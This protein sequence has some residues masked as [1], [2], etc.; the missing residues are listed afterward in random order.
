MFSKKFFSIPVIL[1]LFLFSACDNFLSGS[2]VKEELEKT[3]SYEL[4]T[5][6][7]V[8]IYA[9]KETGSI[10]PNN[11][12]KKC[13][14][15]DKIDLEF[16]ESKN[17]KFSRWI[18]ENKDTGELLTDSVR[19]YN[20]TSTICTAEILKEANIL[21]KPL[22]YERPF[23]SDFSPVYDNTGVPKNSTIHLLFNH[24]LSS[25][26]D[27]SRITISINGEK[28]IRHFYQPVMT[29]KEITIIADNE[30][31]IQTDNNLKEISVRIPYDF[32]YT[33]ESGE[34][35]T[36]GSS[37]NDD[38]VKT[39]L[40]NNTTTEK[41][42]IT[43]VENKEYGE[44]IY[45]GNSVLNYGDKLSAQFIPK[46]GYKF[47]NW[48][49]IGS[50]NSLSFENTDS[51]VLDF[52]STGN[53][54]VIL[55]PIVVSKPYVLEYSPKNIRSGVN[56]D[57]LIEI[58][59]NTA[60]DISEFRFTQ[61]ELDSISDRIPSLDC[62][63][64]YGVYAYYTNS[65][66]KFFKNL[67]IENDFQ[68]NISVNFNKPLLS[69]D[70]KI[71]TIEADYDNLIN[72][73][74]EAYSTITV[75]LS[76][77]VKNELSSLGEDFTWE[78]KINSSHDT[79]APSVTN[80]WIAKTQAD[81]QNGV[82]L[83][84][85]YSSIKPKF[86]EKNVVNN[87]LWV[88]IDAIDYGSGVSGV[89][90]IAKRIEDVKG[91]PVNEDVKT[92]QTEFAP[93][94]NENIKMAVN[95]PLPDF[96][97]GLIETDFYVKDYL[98]N[99]VKCG[100]YV[101]VKDTKLD[102]SSVRLFNRSP[103]QT[104]LFSPEAL[105]ES[106][107][108]IYIAGAE[109]IFYKDYKSDYDELTYKAYWGPDKNNPEYT[110]TDFSFK[111]D[112]K[113]EEKEAYFTI[114]TIDKTKHNYLK[115]E[116]T[117]KAGNIGVV[118]WVIPGAMN[119]PVARQKMD[120]S[121]VDIRAT[122]DESF[123]LDGVVYY[124][125]YFLHYYIDGEHFAEE[126][127]SPYGENDFQK[128]YRIS[129]WNGTTSV[130]IRPEYYEKEYEIYIQPYLRTA[131]VDSAKLYAFV[132]KYYQKDDGE[133]SYGDDKW[134]SEY[135]SSPLHFKYMDYGLQNSVLGGVI[136]PFKVKVSENN[137]NKT[138]L[139]SVD[140]GLVVSEVNRN[141]TR[142]LITYSLKDSSKLNSTYICNVTRDSS[143]N[144]I[145]SNTGTFDWPITE[146]TVYYNLSSVI[147]G[148]IVWTDTI[149]Q[150]LNI[151]GDVTPPEIE[152]KEDYSYHILFADNNCY[153]ARATDNV[154]LKKNE[155]D[156]VEYTY[157]WVPES[158]YRKYL[159]YGNYTDYEELQILLQ[160]DLKA[161]TLS[162][163]PSTDTSDYPI[164]IYKN[165]ISYDPNEEYYDLY[166]FVS[167][168]S[169]NYAKRVFNIYPSKD[170]KLSIQKNAAGNKLYMLSETKS[171][172]SINLYYLK[173]SN[174]QKYKNSI[175]SWNSDGINGYSS[176]IYAGEID[177]SG[178]NNASQPA[179][180]NRF[181]R[182]I[183][184]KD[185]SSMYFKPIYYYIG[186]E[187]CTVKQAVESI[188]PG[189]HQIAV[190][191]DAPW[192][193][194]ILYSIDNFEDEDLWVANA[195]YTDI[196]TFTSS[197]TY[198]FSTTYNAVYKKL[199]P[200]NV[201]VGYYYRAMIIFADGT[202]ELGPVHKAE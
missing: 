24:E 202:Y 92:A 49:I 98:G 31:L 118:N 96:E 15:S 82:N 102:V 160:T 177:F 152:F 46:P 97:D 199:L 93:V 88:F 16:V 135:T 157:F 25:L 65:N 126:P 123:E 38:I 27:L 94:S 12:D 95:I 14:V 79:I 6:F 36:I 60:L 111:V 168:S 84:E 19:F 1:V 110:S 56:N 50:T 32:F 183:F 145:Y 63:D 4:S 182:F 35:I 71:L 156:E 81:A 72:M 170:L 181:L 8:R 37:A 76:K 112:E 70:G 165:T 149:S 161:T 189:K 185:D 22:C 171:L 52:I 113:T 58:N 40:I 201:P 191:T 142:A 100:T 196:N 178:T 116:I 143:D 9:D 119:V 166:L 105:E 7:V 159:E 136:G 90:V 77:D 85:E 42:E 148:K 175:S 34:K 20:P 173:N 155:N 153:Y 69:E 169:G 117:D 120:N 74:G 39:F 128:K 187:V 132:K 2:D 146:S 124:L 68:E 127:L 104:S 129:S 131:E 5:P 193:G 41:L 158:Y 172:T 83:C 59:F 18:A 140:G 106:A 66:K 99:K 164:R 174:W 194:Q 3:I 57:S 122:K 151:T 86:N 186:P 43:F 91:N 75:T 190:L 67:K 13:R 45:S 47:T 51:P 188:D 103:S 11:E 87:N 108:T 176:G 180:N 29:E 107:K 179:Y 62:S 192:M 139:T 154:G 184:N 115:I 125:S 141:T 44:I 54:A 137:N 162:Y 200:S 89:Y 114:D 80:F 167:D 163:N 64:E 134:G 130:S 17:Y 53:G 133:D 109:D 78:Y 28:T 144:N 138:A 55:E 150:N 30:N 26:N 195:A 61:S 101:L 147:D 198:N 73:F 48:K 23:V 33:T 197:G 10:I 121:S 21:I